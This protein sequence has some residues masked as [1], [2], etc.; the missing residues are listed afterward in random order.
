MKR[1]AHLS[2]LLFSDAIKGDMHKSTDVHFIYEFAA[3]MTQMILN[4]NLNEET[5]TVQES[6]YVINVS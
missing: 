4:E 2:M 6:K 1:I 3:N 5:L